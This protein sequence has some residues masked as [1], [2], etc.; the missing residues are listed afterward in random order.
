MNTYSFFQKTIRGAGVG[1][2]ACCV[3]GDLR[4]GQRHRWS[5]ALFSGVFYRIFAATLFLGAAGLP[6]VIS[7]AP[8]PSNYPPSSS[9]NNSKSLFN[10]SNSESIENNPMPTPQELTRWFND[11]KKKP[12]YK[13]PVTAKRLKTLSTPRQEI[14]GGPEPEKME[15]EYRIKIGPNLEVGNRNFVE[16]SKT[17]RDYLRYGVVPLDRRVKP[18]IT[19]AI[20]KA[21]AG[22]SPSVE[23]NN[24]IRLLNIDNAQ[25]IFD[26]FAKEA[27][28][29]RFFAFIYSKE[30]KLSTSSDSISNSIIQKLGKRPLDLRLQIEKLKKGENTNETAL[31]MEEYL[32]KVAGKAIF[33]LGEIN[34][35]L[36][37]PITLVEGGYRSQTVAPVNAI[38]LKPKAK[39]IVE[40]LI[41]KNPD[42]SVT[43]KLNPQTRT[44]LVEFFKK[45]DEEI[46][47]NPRVPPEW[48]LVAD[49]AT[50]NVAIRDDAGGAVITRFCEDS[51]RQVSGDPDGKVLF[52]FLNLFHTRG[53]AFSGLEV[54]FGKPI[55]H[56]K[57]ADEVK[58]ILLACDKNANRADTTIITL[59]WKGQM[60]SVKDVKSG[61][62]FY[63]DPT[64]PDKVLTMSIDEIVKRVSD[65]AAQNDNGDGI[66]VLELE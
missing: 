17:I 20:T 21:R 45:R 66:S 36:D 50:K 1:C 57:E 15:M 7:A 65:K 5:P 56:S 14:W 33:K 6:I 51:L 19:A 58:R 3:R 27:A 30:A 26:A 42:G 31:A 43:I 2:Q 63:T 49:E 11:L 38:F 40:G 61:K 24:L 59:S 8:T 22:K 48:K 46:K 55:V 32:L 37:E 62:V 25:D 47:K 10:S 18:T 60:Y 35:K 29:K 13:E 9:R 4:A 41:V 23:L 34:G 64:M 54:L 52:E 28:G 53:F 12:E 39:K 16:L 44:L